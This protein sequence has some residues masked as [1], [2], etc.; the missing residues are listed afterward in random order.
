M[1]MILLIPSYSDP[2]IGNASIGDASISNLIEV[3]LF[4]G[5]RVGRGL[6]VIVSDK[7]GSVVGENEAFWLGALDGVEL[8]EGNSLGP[9]LGDD[10]FE[11]R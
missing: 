9:A 5:L 11:G 3:G 2:S 10:D 7:V 8:L 6:G 4:V 1:L